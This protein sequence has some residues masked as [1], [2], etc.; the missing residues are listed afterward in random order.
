MGEMRSPYEFDFTSPPSVGVDARQPREG[1]SG[2]GRVDSLRTR[3]RT[4]RRRRRRGSPSP[5]LLG[6][7][8][9]SPAMRIGL[10]S[11]SQTRHNRYISRR[12]RRFSHSP[13]HLALRIGTRT[14]LTTPRPSTPDHPAPTQPFSSSLSYSLSRRGFPGRAN[15]QGAGNVR[16]STATRT[17]AS[18]S[19][20]RTKRKSEREIEKRVEVEAG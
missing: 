17:A 2:V 16:R 5:L 1:L 4:R 12:L 7:S 6:A 20:G 18:R 8:T 19:F 9:A 13:I 10:I 14:L 3:K 15:T 11:N